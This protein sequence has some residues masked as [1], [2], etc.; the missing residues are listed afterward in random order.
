MV[1]V[2]VKAK[3]SRKANPAWAGAEDTLRLTSSITIRTR[4]MRKPGEVYFWNACKHLRGSG[5]FRS[6]DSPVLIGT[7]EQ[8]AEK[9]HK[10][11]CGTAQGVETLLATSPVCVTQVSAQKRARTWGTWQLA[12]GFT[13]CGK[14]PLKPSFGGARLQPSRTSPLF[15]LVTRGLQPASDGT[16]EF[17]RSL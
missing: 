6:L 8:A 10:H 7:T 17:S 12:P 14:T 16:F 1:R 3:F 9:L 13:G 15:S 4:K 2:W 11:N 5:H